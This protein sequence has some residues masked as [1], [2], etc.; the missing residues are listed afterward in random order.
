MEKV[1]IAL[2]GTGV[3][4]RDYHLPVLLEND[5]VEVVAAGN[6]RPASLDA[7]AQDFDIPNTYTDFD[8]MAQDPT[9][10]AVVIGL[11][12]YL[13]APVTVRMLGEGKHVLCEKPMAMTVA[14]ARE[15]IEASD[16]STRKLMIAHM[17]RFDREVRW[18]RDVIDAGILGSIFKVKAHHVWVGDG[19]RPNSWFV[20]PEYAGG[21][22]L[23][24]MG[25][26]PID[27]ISFLF[28][29]EARPT[30]VLAQTGAHFRCIDVEDTAIVMVEYDNGM[31]ATIE[32]GW[33]HNFA[34]GPEGAL[35]VFGTKG[36]ARTFPTEL[37]C[38]IGNAWGQYRPSMPPRRQQC[39]LP[40]YAAQMDH[41]IDCVLND[42][43]P[44]PDGRQGLRSMII[45]EAAYRSA[46]RGKSVSL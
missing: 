34:D 21:G 36:Y 41:F 28:H 13:H 9:I 38:Q 35:E 4:I 1:R 27:T 20:R 14:E 44:T 22:A 12:N 7:L 33:Y 8:R 24:D 40:M 19:P 39:D 26:H 17:W 2:L 32:A 43:D 5:R 45:L 18:L 16:A 3:I 31:V 10:D 29:D 37:H 25:I 6:L 11:P 30:K 42:K 23:A 46:E 15:M